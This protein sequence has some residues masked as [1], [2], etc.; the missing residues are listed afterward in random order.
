MN[1]GAAGNEAFGYGPGPAFM[2]YGQ[3]P[4]GPAGYYGYGGMP[5]Y[6]G[7]APMGPGAMPGGAA[8][9]GHGGGHGAGNPN[10]GIGG[11]FSEIANGGSGL[12]SLSKLIDFSDGTFLKGAAVGAI[13]VLLLTNDDVKHALFGGGAKTGAS[14]DKGG[15]K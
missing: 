10:D 3:A 14:S 11:F 15:A 12:S 6:P 5:P 13:A 2:G 8:H 1:G 7:Y 4:G 9:G